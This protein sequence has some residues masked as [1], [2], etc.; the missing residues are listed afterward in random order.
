MFW[1]C[2]VYFSVKQKPSHRDLG[3]EITVTR[4]AL[5]TSLTIPAT[6]PG[7][8]LSDAAVLPSPSYSAVPKSSGTEIT[9]TRY[10]ITTLVDML[11][12]G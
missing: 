7:W 1:S 11:A 5:I 12:V 6:T 3:T 8:T 4:Y 10:A 2:S 9:V